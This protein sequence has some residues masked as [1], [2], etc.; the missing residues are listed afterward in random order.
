MSVLGI[1]LSVIAQPAA[2]I[3]VQINYSYDTT[4]FFGNGNPQGAIAGAQAKAALEAAASFYSTILTDTFSLIHTPPQF[5]SSQFDGQVTWQWTENFNNPT[6]NSA[7]AVTNATIAAD[8]YIIYTG[9]RSLSVGEPGIGG[10]GG[11]GW[12][13]NPTGSFTIQDINQISAT[14]TVFQ[15]EVEHRGQASGFARWG[16]VIA[17]DNDGSTPWFFNHLATPSGNVTDFYSVAIHELGH[18]LGFGSSS[19]WQT[20]VSGS[21]FIGA[22]AKAQNGG[23]AVPLSP[24]LMHWLAG[25][26]SVV[27]GTST[28]Q[29]TAMDPDLQNDTRKQLTALDA[30]GLKDIGW[31][32]GAVPEPSTAVLM[33]VAGLIGYSAGASSA[34]NDAALRSLLLDDR[35]RSNLVDD[36][37]HLHR[38]AARLPRR[39]LARHADA[40]PADRHADFPV[41]RRLRGHA[42]D[43]QP[44]RT[45][46]AGYSYHDFVAYY[47]LTTISRAFSSMPGL[48]GGIALQIRNGEIKK[49]LVQPV[50]LI[51]FLLLHARGPQA[52]VLRHRVRAVRARVLSVPRLL[53]GLAA[54]GCDVGLH[55]VADFFVPARLLPGSHDRHDRLLVPGSQL[56]AVRVHAV[57]LLLLR[58]HVSARYAAR[59]RG[60]RSCKSSRCNT[61]HT[62][63]SAVF[64]QKIT[65]H[66][67]W[68]GLTIEAAWVLFFIVASRVTFWRG[69]KRYSGFGG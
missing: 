30:A 42:G 39:L 34:T 64:L 52:R 62:F 58:P 37:S 31:S 60:T 59:S 1:S 14:T 25:T 69:V 16:G 45:N 47:L 8:Q 36:S 15:N 9:A 67:L 35:S 29:E 32:L 28:S 26:T 33:L 63:P 55:R 20:L 4:N 43:R 5:H 68:I 27:Y 11:F 3:N 13:S 38:G 49:Y 17:F 56:A 19:E 40:V 57:Q 2:A 53:P 65:G 48:A 12:S 10:P 61:W 66:D 21:N 18:S 54:A 6:T 7:T 24:D 41:G 50:D 44:A 51:G 22:N 46:I 23:N